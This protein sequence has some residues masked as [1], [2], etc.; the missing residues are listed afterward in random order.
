MVAKVIAHGAT[1][2]EARRR[3]VRSLEDLVALGVTTNQVFLRSC[4]RHPVFADGGAT[5]AFIAHHQSELLAS[6][7]DSG[8][9]R[10]RAVALAAVLIFETDGG[11]PAK[12]LLRSLA[13]TLPIGLLLETGEARQ[14][15]QLTQT[16]SRS[17]LVVAEGREHRLELVALGEGAVRFVID[18]VMEGAAYLRDGAQLWMHYA[19]QPRLVND[20]TRCAAERAGDNGCDGKVR[21]SMNGRVVALLVA[22]GDEVQAGQPIVTLEAMKMEHV[23]MAPVAGRVTGLTVGMGEQVT[24]RRVLAEIEVAAEAAPSNVEVV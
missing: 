2:D 18:G 17:F 10:E 19:G 3:L 14:A 11:A 9:L 12:P 23:H 7:V 15:V 6:D 13:H 16:G 1:R 4:L 24:A 21:A 8:A 22:E 20:L 5:T